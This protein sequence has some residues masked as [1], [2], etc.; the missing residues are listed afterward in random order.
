MLKIPVGKF[1]AYLFDCDGT[2]ADS[3]PLHHEAWTKALSPFGAQFPLNLFYEWAGRPTKTIVSLLNEKYGLA[4]PLDVIDRTREAAYL[5]SLPRIQPIADIVAHIEEG[6]RLGLPMAV[7]SGSPR[8]SVIRTLTFL[9][10]LDRFRV[11]VGAEDYKHGKPS[12]EP[13]LTAAERLGVPPTECL[14]F[15]DA[16]LGVQS[17]IAAGMRWAK[18]PTPQF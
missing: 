14:V 15:E 3:M 10:L 12:P 17:A 2:I 6:Q 5:E 9:N 4:M 13:F 18:L 11:I 8:E 1:S 16:D 7:V